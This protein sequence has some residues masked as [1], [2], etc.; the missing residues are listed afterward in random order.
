MTVPIK[1]LDV[2]VKIPNATVPRWL[3]HVG[4]EVSKGQPVADTATDKAVVTLESVATGVL[5][6]VVGL[7]GDQISVGDVSAFGGNPAGTVPHS[8]HLRWV[9][10]YFKQ[11]EGAREFE[12]LIY[13]SGVSY[14]R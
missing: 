7:E 11:I 9:S 12:R 10:G 6:K 2:G 14:P 4:A 1:T 5:L 8:A 3:V 13:N